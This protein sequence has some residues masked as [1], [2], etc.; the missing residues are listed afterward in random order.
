MSIKEFKCPNCG[1]PITFDPG[2]QEMLCP[3]CESTL[4]V[5][6]LQNLDKHLSEAH[7]PEPLEW[8]YG[9][10]GWKDGEQDGLVVYSCRSCAGEIVADETL[11]ATSCPFCDNPVVLTSK[12]SGSLRPDLVIPFKVGKKEAVEALK[13]HYLG[14]KLLPRVFKDQNHLEEVKGVYVP[15]W[16]FDA[17]MDA[18]IEYKATKVRVWSDS[19]YR[20]KETSFFRNIRSGQ[21]GFS[22]VPVDGSRAIDDLLTQSIEP[23]EMEE[24]VSFQTPYLAGYFANK[25]V[26]FSALP[27]S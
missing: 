9:N 4:N 12:F 25:L 27:P 19:Q 23:F 22:K 24:A 26:R 7:E 11:G 17:E 6:A 20:Y 2:L 10:T 8:G 16:L 1:A 14:K 21:I 3:Y 5:E 15:F 18:D 13:R